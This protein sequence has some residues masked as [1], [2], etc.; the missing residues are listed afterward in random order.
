MEFPQDY[1]DIIKILHSTVGNSQSHYGFVF[2]GYNRI[3]GICSKA[4]SA[5]NKKSSG[6]V[7]LPVQ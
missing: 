4:R 7:R 2:L 5:A 6:A 1:P 3:S